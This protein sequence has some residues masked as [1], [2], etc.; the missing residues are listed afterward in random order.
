MANRT[1]VARAALPT[2][3]EATPYPRWGEVINGLLSAGG[4]FFAGTVTGDTDADLVVETPFDPAMVV[5]YNLTDPTLCVHLPTMDAGDMLKLTDAPAL[6]Q[7]TTTGITLGAK[8][9]TIGQDADLNVDAQV[10]HYVAIGWSGAAGG[11]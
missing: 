4:E 7:V 5:A 8:Q 10:I 2:G 6:T 9:F 3:K 1:T 11:A